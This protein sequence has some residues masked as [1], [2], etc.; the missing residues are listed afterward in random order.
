MSCPVCA[1]DN[2]TGATQCVACGALLSSSP[3]LRPG[4]VI[5]NRYELLAPLGRGGMGIVFKARDRMLDETVAVKFLDVGVAPSPV[6]AERFRAE[7]RLARKV[8]H[9]GVCRIFEY[10]EDAGLRYISLAYVDGVDLKRLLSEKGSLPSHQAI[11]LGIA[12]AEALQAIHDEGIVHRDLKT[13]NL[14]QDSRGVVRLMDFGLAKEWMA[15]GPG[16]TASGQVVGTPDYMSPEQAEGRKAD[17]RSDIFALGV[18]LYELLTGAL[19]FPADTPMAALVKRLQEEPRLDG[20]AAASI[21]RP[22]VAVLRKALARDPQQRFATASDLA[23]ALRYVRHAGDSVGEGLLEQR[24]R[25]E[26]AFEW[27]DA[28]GAAA[29][30]RAARPA[31][32][33]AEPARGRK[34]LVWLTA[35]FGMLSALSWAVAWNS[36]EAR[37]RDAE[38]TSRAPAPSPP[39]PTAAASEPGIWVTPAVAAT[40]DPE[41]ARS[42]APPPAPSQAR[43]PTKEVSPL[44]TAAP[45]PEAETSSATAMSAAIPAPPSASPSSVARPPEPTAAP[46]TGALQLLVVPAAEAL[47]DG[48]SLGEISSS[49]L[50]LAPGPH[51]VRILHPDYQPLQRIVTVR[52]GETTRLVLDLAEKAIRRR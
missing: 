32:P 51:V 49:E 26:T 20:P 22:V 11:E 48:R 43:R 45:S 28:A 35:L 44:R 5:A 6:A 46:S 14:M 7:I 10:G 50:A 40:A 38:P 16:A 9:R 15:A 4:A 33:R 27:T 34:P 12:V 13:S 1:A 42:G 18:V 25:A 47:V 21:P 30:Y 19:P 37:S 39:G 8:T 17:Q 2:A 29:P 24:H 3:L 31:P 23:D 41:L 36:Y 52:A